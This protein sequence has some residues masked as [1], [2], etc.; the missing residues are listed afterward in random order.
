MI[1]TSSAISSEVFDVT[2]LFDVAEVTPF[3]TASKEGG[4]D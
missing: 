2:E 3:C 1:E 4:V